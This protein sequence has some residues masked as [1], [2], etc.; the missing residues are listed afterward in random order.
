MLQ[1]LFAFW[2]ALLRACTCA[3]VLEGPAH[4]ALSCV[5]PVCILLYAVMPLSSADFPPHTPRYALVDA[6]RG[7]AM[8]W[9][10]LFHFCFDL[11]HFGLW[12]QNFRTDP[13][14]TAQRTAIVSLF[15][16]CA[17]L[18]QA[19]AVQ[20]GQSWARFGRR[21]LQ[22][23]GCAL[24]VSAAS[25]A[26]FPQSFIY[27]GV[28]HGMAV[29]LCLVRWSA[30]WGRGLWWA[31]GVALCMPSIA[32]YVFSHGAEQWAPWFN[33]PAFNWLGLVSRKPFTQDYVPVFPWLGVMWW[34]MASGQWLLS[35]K[36]GWLQRPLPGF[37]KGPAVLGRWS[38]SY[39][40]VHQ[41][42]LMGGLMAFLWLSKH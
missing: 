12:G 18:S 20:Q 4:L 27:F 11:A 7:C 41:P 32:A 5:L 14:W 25:Y 38:L 37:L 17:G 28:L 6:L 31:G 19:I 1:T 30:G 26:M 22:I 15:L 40:M 42:V 13:V 9:M 8:V 23:A 21:W 3:A 29:M 34:G 2:R 33:A 24:L 36:P 10:T 35:R 16:F 39:Y